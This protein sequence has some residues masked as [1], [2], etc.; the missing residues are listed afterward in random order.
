V[1][2]RS[3]PAVVDADG[4]AAPPRSNGE[5]VFAAPWES[6]AFGVAVALHDAGVIDFE[7]FR[8]RLIDEIAAWEIHH[9]ATADGYRYYER[10]LAAL[11]RTVTESGLVD[12]RRIDAVREE[13]RREWDHDHDTHET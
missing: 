7:A 8:A 13:L 1:S 3:D 12:N 9:G 4:P 2:G 10:W 5:L 6:R 11:E